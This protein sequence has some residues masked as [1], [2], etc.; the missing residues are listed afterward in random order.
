[1]KGQI[2][3]VSSSFPESLQEIL[4]I[5]P[6]LQVVYR[7]MGLPC[8]GPSIAYGGYGM[9]DFKLSDTSLITSRPMS[10]HLK[11]EMEDII[12]F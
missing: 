11:I 4:L 1:M 2:S 3:L 6:T 8:P 7:E 10:I 12:F 9:V 5:G